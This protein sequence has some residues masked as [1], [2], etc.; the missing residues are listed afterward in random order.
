MTDNKSPLVLAFEGLPDIGGRY[1]E[2]RCVNFRPGDADKGRGHFSL[3]F[4]A[5]DSETG[6]PVAIKVMDPDYLTDLYRMECF[7]REPQI[8]STLQAHQRSLK[9]VEG[10]KTFVINLAMVSVSFSVPI[11]FF[12]TEWLDED[13]EDYFFSQTNYSAAVKLAI[14]RQ[15]VLAIKV[16]HDSNV[17]H[18]DIK[19]DNFRV[20]IT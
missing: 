9:L 8:I 18:R 7:R 17:H 12:V 13:I 14:F 6:R 1:R 2:V 11:D 3:I 5:E 20:R 16:L 15:I 19:R 4:R 10:H